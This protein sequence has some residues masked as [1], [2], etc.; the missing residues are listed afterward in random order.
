[1][2]SGKKLFFAALVILTALLAGCGPTDEQ[3]G[4][5]GMTP[6]SQM[7]LQYAQQFSVSY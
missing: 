6:V 1:M 3:T 7:E 5:E 4:W 2:K